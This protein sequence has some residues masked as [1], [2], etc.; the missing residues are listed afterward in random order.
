MIGNNYIHLIIPDGKIFVMGDN[1]NVSL[2][3]RNDSV[4]LIDI[5]DNIV[6]K[7]LFKE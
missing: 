2:D 3:S 5:N 6:G 7:V 1:R 4:G